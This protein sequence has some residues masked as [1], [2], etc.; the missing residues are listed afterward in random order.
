M[1]R[2]VDEHA[3]SA[4]RSLSEAA[5][6]V[7]AE[8]PSARDLRR[9]ATRRR[10]VQLGLVVALVGAVA[11]TQLVGSSSIIID[12]AP[13]TDQEP[14][15]GPSAGT[16][17]NATGWAWQPIPPAPVGTRYR[18]APVWTG[19]E[20]V[21]WG[22]VVRS[23]R[24]DPFADDGAA[25]DP[26]TDEWRDL[27]P[28]PLVPRHSP[29]AMWTGER[30]VLFGG[31]LGEQRQSDGAFYD[32]ATDRWQA[33]PDVQLEGRFGLTA[34]AVWAAGELLVWGEVRDGDGY[35]V[36]GRA[37]NAATETWR[38]INAH[39]AAVSGSV[40]WTGTQVIAVGVDAEANWSEPGPGAPDPKLT[41]VA[42]DPDTDRWDELQEPALSPRYGHASVWTG[43]TL[44][45]WGGRDGN[46]QFADGA[47]YRPSAG[48]MAMPASPLEGRADAIVAW[49][50]EQMLVWGGTGQYT[51]S[52]FEQ[53][54]DGAL[55]DPERSTWRRLPDAPFPGDATYTPGVWTGDSLIVWG[56]VNRSS[57]GAALNPP[58]P[59]R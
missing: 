33:L 7:A 17:T 2:S 51:G 26:S 8:R 18:H 45:V 59:E 13:R 54:T 43:E 10:P 5:R 19:S 32:P 36:T 39:R 34:N 30:V 56:Q 15:V 37:Y 21:V 24:A 41:A 53:F 38:E 6:Q 4:T 11:L 46:G 52:A 23:G 50:G 58:A 42:Y 57:E 12:D 22:G 9:R 25:F 40:T 31:M 35:A 55:Y 20:M 27:A 1:N 47:V 44:I 49:T 3:R 16:D 29:S 28:S 48:W 14:A